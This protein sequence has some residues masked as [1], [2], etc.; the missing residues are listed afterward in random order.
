[1]N[2]VASMAVAGDSSERTSSH[3]RQPALPSFE[4]DQ[5]RR[6]LVTGMPRIDIPRQS[7]EVMRHHGFGRTRL[8]REI[9]RLGAG[10]GFLGPSE[11]F[12][13]RLY[14]PDLDL[15]EKLRFIGNRLETTM[16]G[17]CNDRDWRAIA[18]DK[19]VTHAVLRDNGFP[20]PS[21]AAFYHP[22]RPAPRRSVALGTAKELR[23]FLRGVDRPLFG[24]PL[25][26]YHSLGCVSIDSF[27]RGTD[28]VKLAFGGHLSLPSLLDYILKTGRSGYLFQER[29]R[30]HRELA[31]RFGPTLST[32]RM[33]VLL[34]PDG[35]ELLQA[36]CKIPRGQNVADNFWR[37]N[38]AGAVDARSGRMMR[39]VSGVGVDQV[40]HTHHPDTG[41]SLVGMTLPR[42]REAVDTCLEASACMPGLRTQSWDVAITERGPVLIEVNSKGNFSGP[43]IASG[44]GFRDEAYETHLKRCGYRAAPLIQRL[45]RSLVRRIGATAARPG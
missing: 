4:N 19:L 44:R 31:E 7:R 11:Y 33:V 12:M 16:H 40:Q 22:R 30:P 20:V 17:A 5:E 8:L 43:Q 39:V 42:W 14:E 6:K 38:M 29:L 23:D 41:M 15:G 21:L 2:T 36:A 34:T 37:G 26:G 35:P 3:P 13:Y 10:P 28:S 27:D 25:G 32:I 18:D 1:M 9:A 45:S 24:K